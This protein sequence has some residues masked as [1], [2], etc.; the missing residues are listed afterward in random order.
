[1]NIGKVTP[2]EITKEMEKSYL[3]YAMS[4]IVSRALPDVRDG[5]KPVHRRILYAMHQ[6]GLASTSK[7]TK[8][9]KVVGETMG[10]YHPHGDAAIYD[11]L[12]RMAQTFSMRY[13]LISG[14]GNFGSI[15][16][17]PAAAMRYTEVKLAPI[18]Q[19]M[20]ADLGKETVEF[21]DNFDASSKEPLFLPAKL[22]N[23]LLMGSEGIAVGMATKIPP[24]NLREVV[25]AIIYMIDHGRTPEK[26]LEVRSEKESNFQILTS[27]PISNFPARFALGPPASEFVRKRSRAGSKAGGQFPISKFD[28][29]V[30]IDQLLKFIKGPDFPT[31]GEIYDAEEIKNA[32]TTGKGKIIIRGKA[33]IEEK[34]TKKFSIVITQLP[35][36]VNKSNL[37]AKI[38]QL[39]RDKKINGVADIRDES[40]RKGISVVIELKR[41]SR[42][43]AILNNL[44]E[45]TN[46]QTTFPANFV[47]LVDRVPK[48]LNLKQIL[49]LYIR[50]RQEIVTKKSI[51]ELK[52]SQ[53]RAHILEGLKIA[54]K[55]LDEVI[56]TIKKSKNAETAKINLMKRFKLTEIQAQAILD[57]QLKRLAHLEQQK[58]EDE[59]QMIK[60]TIAYLTDLLSHPRK[61]LGVVKSELKQLAK[62]YGDER[63]TKIFPQK[64]SHFKKEDLV[65]K[66]EVITT[67]TDDGYIK[68]L[69]V[70]TY[71]SQRRG[72]KGVIGMT[73]KEKDEIAHILTASTHDDLLFFTNKGRVFSQKVYELPE[74]SRR[75]K[76]QAIVNF[77]DLREGE[78]VTAMLAINKQQATGNRQQ[79]LL[80]ITRKG[81]VKKTKVSNFAN[82]RSNGIIAI[83]LQKDDELSWV[84]LTKGDNHVML[85]TSQGK[86]I[87]FSEKDVRSM[88]RTAAGVRG[89]RLKK[90]DLVIGMEVFPKSPK[91]PT[92][93]RR[94]FF[95]DLLVVSRKGLGKRTPVRFFPVQKRGGFGVKV[96]RVTQK[97]GEITACRLV[98]QKDKQVVL[99]SR[100]AQIIKLPLKNIPQLGRNTQ[101]VILM[102]FT[103]PKD[104]V[105]AMTTI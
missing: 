19:E 24:H 97:T 15:D 26:K 102:R 28:S 38:A 10:K 55:F 90:G 104:S 64:L 41:G 3:D 17:D 29:D 99:T 72:G 50:H 8:S 43:K 81:V 4:V 13:P 74:G 18:S 83:N 85:I 2:V 80:M 61:I 82:I 79:F 67:I 44:Y 37:V 66:G 98:T 62:K 39:V 11:A 58:I 93:K 84:K 103:N 21:T 9:A 78:N 40:D 14:Q 20:L 51:F 77:I 27:P 70:G 95:H 36:Q 68:R 54:L 73:T 91:K 71:K 32:Y 88:G 33:Q 46:L 57:M 94:R 101:G 7:R 6:M 35:Y 89:I 12:T 86:S 23:L 63:K 56:S 5:L 31:G 92:D 34:K 100:A 87:R 49:T 60:E 30:T 69:P 65:P 22:P 59:Y 48:T 52:Q 25:E 105:A 75:S 53:K 16:G 42:P 45:H 76:G 96:A 1:M 47:I